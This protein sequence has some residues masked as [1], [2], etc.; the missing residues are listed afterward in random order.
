MT[1]SVTVRELD[2]PKVSLVPAGAG[3]AIARVA[4]AKPLALH[5]LRDS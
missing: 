2:L 4:Q 3:S 1:V 5:L